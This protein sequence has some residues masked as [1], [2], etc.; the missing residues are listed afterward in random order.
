MLR[1]HDNI[2]E[3][4]ED[5]L[6]PGPGKRTTRV[7]ALSSRGERGVHVVREYAGS[8]RL[9]RLFT[10]PR[11]SMR[12]W[13]GGRIL[14]VLGLPAAETE[15]WVRG[16]GREF[17]IT[18]FA[19]GRP[20]DA[21]LESRCRDLGARDALAIQKAVARETADLVRRAHDAGVWPDLSPRRLL[22]RES[23]EGRRYAFV[24]L[25]GL[26][27]ARGRFEPDRAE[28]LAR[29][30]VPPGPIQRMALVRGLVRYATNL[31]R[32]KRR[33]LLEAVF[34]RA[35]K[36][37]ALRADRLEGADE[38]GRSGNDRVG[39]DVGPRSDEGLGSDERDPVHEQ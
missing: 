11:P 1:A 18:R 14:E 24:D 35:E 21:Y 28:E 16:A 12:A 8:G 23:A 20:I 6:S 9:A 27:T 37:G 15:A 36:L 30:L 10:G 33:R 4:D 7:E 39:D 26:R 3:G 13:I 31:D 29:L 22:V 17:L 32:S 19:P 38:G 34:P 25:E 5:L 2:R